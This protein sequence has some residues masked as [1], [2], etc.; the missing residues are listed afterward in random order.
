MTDQENR[1][2]S[3]F[4]QLSYAEQQ[5]KWR[6]W[7]SKPLPYQDFS[8]PA[9]QAETPPPTPPE[10]QHFMPPS[11]KNLDRVHAR[12]SAAVARAGAFTPFTSRE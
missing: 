3:P 11:H 7:R 12:I 9:P 5:E 10:P 6:T 4:S 1:S 8:V 2:R